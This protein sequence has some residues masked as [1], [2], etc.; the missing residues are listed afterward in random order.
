M[1]YNS[2]PERLYGYFSGSQPLNS[3]EE[4]LYRKSSKIQT[5]KDSKGMY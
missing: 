4:P 5:V 3:M 1:K 2:I